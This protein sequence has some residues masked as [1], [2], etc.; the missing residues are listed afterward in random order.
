MPF[1]FYC[2]VRFDFKLHIFYIIYKINVLWINTGCALTKRSPYFCCKI[3]MAFRCDTNISNYF[4]HKLSLTQKNYQHSYTAI[5]FKPMKKAKQ[6]WIQF[7]REGIFMFSCWFSFYILFKYSGNH[8]S[9]HLLYP[10]HASFPSYP[11]A[12]M[13]YANEVE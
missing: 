2:R 1:S 6:Q 4:I 11:T 3:T 9:V 13:Y 8:F 12:L 5:S 7:L 10:R